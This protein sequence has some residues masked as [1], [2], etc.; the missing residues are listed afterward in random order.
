MNKTFSFAPG[1]PAN[2]ATVD[3]CKK[4]FVAYPAPGE[5]KFAIAQGSQFDFV[6]ILAQAVTRAG[7]TSYGPVL[8]ELQTMPVYHGVVGDV[9]FT[10][11]DHIGL[12]EDAFVVAKVSGLSNPLSLGFLA[13]RD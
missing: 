9:K 13:E 4:L 12:A 2:A 3:Y 5:L 8:N 10:K 1:V 7:T 11:T 6:H